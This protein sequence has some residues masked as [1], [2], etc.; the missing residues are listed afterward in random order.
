MADS[1]DRDCLPSISDYLASRGIAV[2][3][4]GRQRRA[5]CPLADHGHRFGFSINEEQGLWH[6]FACDAGDDVINLHMRLTGAGFLDAARELGALQDDDSP[7]ARVQP[8]R[9]PIA[10]VSED[11]AAQRRKRARAAEIWRAALPIAPDSI[12]AAYLLGRGCCLPPAAGDLR[13]LPDLRLFGFS[14]VAIVGRVSAAACGRHGQGL[15]L[16]WLERA[17]DRWRRTERRY[18]GKKAGGVVRLWPDD[19]VSLGL[20]V[21]EGVETA[22]AAARM[23]AP[24]WASMDA[25]NLAAFPVLAGVE[26]LTI[27]ADRD[28]SGTGQDAAADVAERWLAA[29]REVTIFASTQIGRDIADEAAQWAA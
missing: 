24:A 17:G 8:R 14:G 16:T 1:I 4:R 10:P 21:A 20:A 13:W 28:E 5:D 18:L 27:F 6:C 9:R 7:A 29:G 3:G 12:A 23:G 22:L 15:H 19:C 25:G 26:T 11:Q 2:K